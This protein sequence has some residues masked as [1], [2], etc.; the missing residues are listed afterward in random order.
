MNPP[1]FH[2]GKSYE[3][4]KQ[5]LLAWNEITELAKAKR[6]VAIALTLPED[7][8]HR[9]REKVFDQMTLDDLKKDTGLE[10]LITFL[11]QHL[12]KDDLADSLE[13][14]EEFEDITRT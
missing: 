10:I 13:K 1:N 8:E 9:I 5:E 3:L 11:D 6:G 14:F 7:D 2:K 12:A 4:Y